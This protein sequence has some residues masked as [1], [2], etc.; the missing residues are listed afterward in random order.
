MVAEIII[1]DDKIMYSLQR[2]T[3]VKK[4]SSPNQFWQFYVKGHTKV[5]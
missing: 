2:Q 5:T 3:A 4:T 1:Y